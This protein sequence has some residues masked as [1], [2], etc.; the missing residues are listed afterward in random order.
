MIYIYIYIYIYRLS[1][2][3][4]NLELNNGGEITFSRNDVS[5]LSSLTSGVACGLPNRVAF[6]VQ[7]DLEQKFKSFRSSLKSSAMYNIV[8]IYHLIYI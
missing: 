4:F 1:E 7:F 8:S 5:G 3:S 2:C 6:P